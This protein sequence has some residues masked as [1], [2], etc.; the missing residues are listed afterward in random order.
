MSCDDF[1]P[2]VRGDFSR[3]TRRELVKL[4]DK[5]EERGEMTTASLHDGVLLDRE[6][7]RAS[8]HLDLVVGVVACV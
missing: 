5:V 2:K 1:H 7:H 4:F 3:Q 6:S 8:A